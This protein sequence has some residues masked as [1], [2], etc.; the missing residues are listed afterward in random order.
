MIEA[1]GATTL[2]GITNIN[3]TGTAAT[4]LGNTNAASV[5]NAG[6]GTAAMSVVNNAAGLS[7]SNGGGFSATPTTAMILGRQKPPPFGERLFC[8]SRGSESLSSLNYP[9]LSSRWAF[10][11]SRIS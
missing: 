5:V 2:T 11:F 7:L 3:T 8:F 10:C 1:C 9:T 6:G 4:S